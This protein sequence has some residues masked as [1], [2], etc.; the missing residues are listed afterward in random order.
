M[1]G[2]GDAVST[3]YLRV[4]MIRP[5]HDIFKAVPENPVGSRDRSRAEAG[6]S[7]ATCSTSLPKFSPLKSFSRLPGKFSM[8]ATMSSL[9]FIRPS[10][11]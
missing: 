8:P 7:V 6:Q 2:I 4:L 1:R 10:F 11:R 9:L 3:Q 5:F